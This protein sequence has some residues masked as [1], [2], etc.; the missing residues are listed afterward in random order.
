MAI[1]QEELDG[2][3]RY[4]FFISKIATGMET[5]FDYFWLDFNFLIDPLQ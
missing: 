4:V 1:S 5:H 3:R 2:E